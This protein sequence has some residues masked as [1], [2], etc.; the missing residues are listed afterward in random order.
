MK[1]LILFIFK[2]IGLFKVFKFINR[3]KI[4]KAWDLRLAICQNEL[5]HNFLFYFKPII[6]TIKYTMIIR[7]I[8]VDKEKGEILL[9]DHIPM[10]KVEWTDENIVS[11]FQY[12]GTIKKDSEGQNDFLKY[13]FNVL[14]RDKTN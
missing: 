3:N 7:F 5:T 6:L 12:P 11:V 9:E 13:R 2:Y 14:T 4:M 8:I 1:I 10:G